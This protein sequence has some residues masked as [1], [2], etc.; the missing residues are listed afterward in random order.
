M[1][2]RAVEA[3]LLQ[4]EGRGKEYSNKMEYSLVIK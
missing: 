4:L 1:G 2:G 3:A